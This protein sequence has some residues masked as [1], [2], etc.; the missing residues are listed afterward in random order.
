MGERTSC[1]YDRDKA[2]AGARTK[3]RVLDSVEETG[4]LNSFSALTLFLYRPVDSSSL[5]VVRAFFGKTNCTLAVSDQYDHQTTM[6][7][8]ACKPGCAGSIPDPSRFSAFSSDMLHAYYCF[9]DF[10]K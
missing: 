6:S 1:G 7:M 3:M 9:T 4:I 8:V 10:T 2:D 5:G